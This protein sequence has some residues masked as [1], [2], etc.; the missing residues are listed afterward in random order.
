MSRPVDRTPAPKP[1][2]D[3]DD[4]EIP[5]HPPVTPKNDESPMESLGE[6]IADVVTGG[7]ASQTTA[8]RPADTDPP[9]RREKPTPR[10]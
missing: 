5:R 6:A 1:N 7:D 9:E 2:S 10:R 3:W 8:E 4:D